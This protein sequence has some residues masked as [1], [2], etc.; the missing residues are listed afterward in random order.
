MLVRISLWNPP[1]EIEMAF[2]SIMKAAE[3][4]HS[5]PSKSPALDAIAA[6]KGIRSRL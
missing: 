1:A 6:L 5:N 4:I 2:E 3:K